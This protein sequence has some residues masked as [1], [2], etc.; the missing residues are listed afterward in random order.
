MRGVEAPVYKSGLDRSAKALRHPKTL[1]SPLARSPPL[2]WADECVRPLDG[3][4]ILLVNLMGFP[5]T[6][7][8]RLRRTSGLRD[9]VRETRLTPEG[10]V[11]PLFV[12][13][14]EGA[15][16]EVR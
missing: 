14:G 6:R 9:L 16:R 2:T 8:R 15:R 11:Y 12:C 4:R 5:D 13:P 3:L 7:L 10:L 1:K